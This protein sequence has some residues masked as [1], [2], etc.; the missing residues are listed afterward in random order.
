MTKFCLNANFAEHAEM[1]L[2]LPCNKKIIKLTKK[3]A[4]NCNIFKYFLSKY[5]KVQD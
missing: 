5:E 1:C 2:Q 3:S 4:T